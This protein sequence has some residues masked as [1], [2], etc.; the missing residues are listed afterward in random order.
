MGILLVLWSPQAD[1]APVDDEIEILLASHFSPLATFWEQNM[2]KVSSEVVK[3]PVTFFWCIERG[4]TS[5][6]FCSR[7]FNFIAVDSKHCDIQAVIDAVISS[8][9]MMTHVWWN[10]LKLFHWPTQL[11]VQNFLISTIVWFKWKFVFLLCH[12]VLDF[13]NSFSIRCIAV[14]HSLCQSLTA[15]CCVATCCAVIYS[16]LLSAPTV[17][18]AVPVIKYL[19]VFA[20]VLCEYSK[21]WIESNT[22][23]YSSIQLDSKRAQLFEIFEYLPSPISYLFNRMTPIFHLSNHA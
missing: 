21:F 13:R 19:H 18:I 3:R 5:A 14:V 16:F 6:W 20:I 11:T 8:R 12:Y 23:S 22:G 15:G 17:F 4:G 7:Y 2:W 9:W 1:F 10:I